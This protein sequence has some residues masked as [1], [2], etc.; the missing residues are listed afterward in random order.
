MK[1]L[2]VQRDLVDFVRGSVVR[3]IGASRYVLILFAVDVEYGDCSFI[4][5][6]VAVLQTM[7]GCQPELRWFIEDYADLYFNIYYWFRVVFIHLA[8]SMH[9]SPLT[10]VR[11]LDSVMTSSFVCLVNKYYTDEIHRNNR[12]RLCSSHLVFIYPRSPSLVWLYLPF[13][14]S[15]LLSFTWFTF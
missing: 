1:T 3:S 14:V 13:E 2:G 11:I 12:S 8:A 10:R 9:T 15:L 4:I 5:W 7:I 6:S